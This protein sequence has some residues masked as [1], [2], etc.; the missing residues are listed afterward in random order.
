MGLAPRRA[1][2]RIGETEFDP[3]RVF[4]QGT[5]ADTFERRAEPQRPAPA[6]EPVDDLGEIFEAARTY[7]RVDRGDSESLRLTRGFEPIL[8]ALN[9]GLPEDQQFVDPGLWIRMGGNLDSLA[10]QMQRRPG[11]RETWNPSTWFRDRVTVRQQ[12]ENIFAEIR[13]RRAKDPAFLPGVPDTWQ[14]YYQ[15]LLERDKKERGAASDVLS[16]TSGFTAGAVGFAGGAREI[17]ADPLNIATLP[18]GGGLGAGKGLVTIAAREALINGAIEALQ[19]PQMAANRE[20]VGD[21]LTASEAA[22]NV[23]TAAAFGG[24]MP[25]AIRG[26]IE[27][28]RALGRGYDWTVGK[29]FAAMPESVQGKWAARMKVAD[30]PIDEFFGGLSHADAADFARDVIGAGALTPEQRAAANVLELEELD[31]A[32]SPYLP[33]LA[34]DREHN[35]RLS[36]AI[37]DII[38]QNRSPLG[39]SPSGPAAAGGRAAASID[40]AAAVPLRPGEA[41]TGARPQSIVSRAIGAGRADFETVKAK[42]RVPESAGDDRAINRAGSSASGRYQFVKGTFKSLYRRVFGGD[43]EQAWNTRRFDVD[44]Q[45]RLMDALLEEN[46][47][48]LERAGVQATTGNLY[49]A[50]FAGADRA[51]RMA[52]ADP[53]TPVSRFFSEEEIEQNPS[54]LGGGRSVSEAIAVIYGKVDGTAASVP[55]R[56]GF[57][58][59]AAGD[60]GEDAAVALL[61]QEAL[62]LGEVAI[63]ETPLATGGALPAMRSIRVRPDQLTVDAERFQFKGGGDEF[64]VTERLRGVSEWNPIYAGRVVVWEDAGGK[65][66]VADGHQRVGLARRIEGEHGQE[67]QLE[68]IVLRESEGVTAEDARTWA[69]LKNIAEGTG[70]AVDAAKVIRQVG[71]EVLEHLPPKSALVRDGAAL[72]RLSD[73]AFG[74]V[75]NEVISPEIAAVVGHLAP[76]NPAGHAGLVELLV[77][78]DPPNR[79]QAESIVRQAIAA[80]FHKSEQVEL[81]GAREITSSL[82]LERAK[83][84]ERGLAS[85]RKLKGVFG[86]ASKNADALEGAGSKIA[87]SKAEQEAQRNAEAIEIV[88]RLAFSQGPVADALNRAAAELAEGGRLTDVVARF[89]ADVR[90]LELADLSRAG[91]GDSGLLAPDGAG[92]GGDARG[93]GEPLQGQPGGEGQPSLLELDQATARF[94]D[95]DG[96]AVKEQADSLVHDFKADLKSSA[97]RQAPPQ[98]A[99]LDEGGDAAPAALDRGAEVDPAIAARQR[100]EAELKAGSP[101]RATAEQDD[102]G[103]LALFDQANE[104][105]FDLEGMTFRLSDE[106]DEISAADLLAEIEGD[107]AAVAAIRGCL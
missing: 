53:A 31:G 58:G 21:E 64:G 45:E 50:H 98:R 81:F 80:G 3:D 13:Q 86:T 10:G 101:M 107:E 82:F 9:S 99:I 38:D 1:P 61:R 5:I 100:Q 20:L 42:I 4:D 57:A 89:V 96:P 30:M 41:S 63:G 49:L 70:T 7:S 62:R 66:F 19:I 102:T 34:G 29:V 16:R 18:L 17:M 27:G 60:A 47:A 11:R 78:L 83:V 75:Y 54:Y 69:A 2:S 71:P 103:G 51:A 39:G 46:A 68:G 72:S 23:G 67:I 106:G 105:G 37:Q 43:A 77:K 93:E 85:L 40:D 74:A 52:K 56:P 15:G 88:S 95:P 36:V 26:G 90:K 48:V 91:A 73:D 87:R 8:E 97:S 84:L 104:P 6:Q 35:Q 92:R 28:G 24:A 44:V 22:F 55:A 25:F 32:S 65:L 59:G 76:D 12:M 33:G 94:S 79:G 14:E